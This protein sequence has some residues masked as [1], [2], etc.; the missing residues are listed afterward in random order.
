MLKDSALGLGS[1]R[2]RKSGNL[3]AAFGQNKLFMCLSCA[4]LT[5][6]CNVTTEQ[7]KEFFE[8]MAES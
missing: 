7:T 4:P 8:T 5:C 6:L 2:T 1:K 3:S